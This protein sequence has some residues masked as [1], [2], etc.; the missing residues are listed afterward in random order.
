MRRRVFTTVAAFGLIAPLI[1]IDTAQAAPS[2]QEPPATSR[3][4]RVTVAKVKK[5]KWKRCADDKTQQCATY[6][7]PMDWNQ[8]K[9]PKYSLAL[10]RLPAKPPKKPKNRLKTLFFNPGGPGG[11]GTEAM[12]LFD[13]SALRKKFHIVS[14]DPRGVPISK[15]LPPSCP[16]TSLG[17]PETG[18]FT[19]LQIATAIADD[20][21]NR[22]CIDAT[23]PMMRSLGTNNVVRDLDTLRQAVGDPKLTY[24]GYSYGTVIGRLYAMRYPDKFRAMLMDGTVIPGNTMDEFAQS[25]VKGTNAAWDLLRSQLS[26]G[27]LTLSNQLSDYLQTSTIAAGDDVVNRWEFW[28]LA[29][30]AG[31]TRDAAGNYTKAVCSLAALAGLPTTACTTSQLSLRAGNSAIAAIRAAQAEAPR[32]TQAIRCSDYR[33]RPSTSAVVTAFEA[34]GGAP[35]T[36]DNIFNRGLMCTGWPTKNLVPATT[37]KVRTQTPLLFVNGIGDSHTSYWG[38]K[39]TAKHFVGHR[40]ITVNTGMHALYGDTASACIRKPVDKYLTTGK[41]PKQN[42]TCATAL[43]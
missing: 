33:G 14:W 15:P 11:S 12:S 8:P 22:D 17:L 37:G 6:K 29:I 19:W 18:P 25:A 36:Y 13:K 20:A 5:I 40:F 26:P 24:I 9:G 39:Q 38:A 31:D 4:D 28:S 2:P 21:N 1:A 32:V 27:V 16:V 23:A 7:V 34:A 10:R 35:E 43:D 3:A 42:L 41:L 30:G